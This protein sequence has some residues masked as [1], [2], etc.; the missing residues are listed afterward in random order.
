MDIVDLFNEVNVLDKEAKIEDLKLLLAPLANELQQLML[1]KA[2]TEAQLSEINKQIKDVE[3]GIR[4]LWEPHI[5]GAESA[6]LDLGDAKLE[7]KQTL[8]VSVAD[9]DNS[10]DY[11][12]DWL[13]S[14]GYKDVMKYDI[15]TNTMKAIA[16]RLAKDDNIK[17]PGLKYST[18]NK[19]KVG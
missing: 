3:S 1:D 6:S 9:E 2:A 10:R 16:S 19:I 8:N 7:I 4:K 14:N 12:I 13:C 17:I 11:A 15:N 5:M 18:Y